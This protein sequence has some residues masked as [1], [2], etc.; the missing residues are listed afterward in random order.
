[1]LLDLEDIAAQI[2]GTIKGDPKM[3]ISGVATIEDAKAGEISFITNTK[4]IKFL[5]E[6]E[7]SAIIVPCDLEE[8]ALG[9]I[10][11]RSD[12]PYFSFLKTV[13][14]FH[15]PLPLLD[16]GI[17]KTAVVGEKT[18]LGEN[19]SIGPY[20]VIGKRCQIG[21]GTILMPGAVL[22]DEVIVGEE[23]LIHSHVCLRERVVVGNRV[24]IHSGAV[25]GSDGFGFAP[26]AGQY[27]KIPQVGT[28]V[29]EDDV[30]IG[31]NVTIDRAT[32]GETRIKRGVKL[33]NLIQVGHNCTIGENTV[34]AG[35]AG[36]SGSTHI[37]KNVRIGGQ[38]GFAGH[39]KVGDGAAVG[40]KSGV[41]KSIPENTYMFGSPAR[42]HMESFRIQGAIHR[43]PERM[44]ELNELKK[45][46]EKL[47]KA[48]RERC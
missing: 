27:F 2:G 29:I 5:N 31:A 13:E 19:L 4:Y 15:P 24:V 20:V 12:N 38:V 39:L 11:I 23:C 9:K 6:T 33:D 47:K 25:V 22:G 42:P 40:A 14:L 32:L 46:I 18:K 41:D 26:E 8:E 43:L 21:S 28:V 45:E 10:L 1:M 30:E 36:L 34:I 16:K 44:K 37:G 48:L 3:K 7:A 17:H 35:Q